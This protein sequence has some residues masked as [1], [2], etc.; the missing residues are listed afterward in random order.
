MLVAFTSYI[1]LFRLKH[2][3]GS[4]QNL[5]QLNK[6]NAPLFTNWIKQMTSKESNIKSLLVGLSICIPGCPPEP[7]TPG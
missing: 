2:Y 6:K 3:V 4:H 5:Q 7:P 1:I